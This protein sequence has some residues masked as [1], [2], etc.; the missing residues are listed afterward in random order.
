M[1]IIGL[2]SYT[3]ESSCALIKDG[4]VIAHLEEERFNREKHTCKFPVNAIRECLKIGGITIHDVDFYTFFWK[5]EIE[6]FKNAFHF[7]K[8]FPDSIN[9]LREPK[10]K[11]SNEYAFFDRLIKQ[12]F[13][14]R[15]IQ[16]TFNLKK[17]P[18]VHYVEHH[19]CHAAS[20]YYL[21]SFNK[22][23]ILTMDGRGEST[24]T[25]I[26]YGQENAIKKLRE[27]TVP[28]SLGHLYAAFTDFLGFKPFHDE[29]K[30]MGMSAYGKENFSD[31][32]DKILC[33]D[34]DGIYKLN[35]SY[36]KFHVK[37]QQQ[38][39]SPKV[40]SL[41]GP[42]RNQGE[43]LLQR[44]Y[45]I[46]Y[47]L[48][49]STEK[50]GIQLAQYTAKITKASNLCLTGGVALNCLMNKKIIENTDFENYFIQPIANDAGASL[51]SAL[52]FYHHILGHN[53]TSHFDS[54]YLGN[55]FSNEEIEKVL[56]NKK[57]V[58]KKSDNI[59]KD[60]AK[61]IVDQKIVGWFQGKME[62]G[63]RA[64]G[65]RSIVVD[66]RN[67]A[68]K[69]T[70]NARVKR[71]EGFRPFAP[72]VLEEKSS[73]YF[74][75]P[76][77]QKSPYM[78]LIGDVNE[79]KIDKIPAVVHADNTARVHTV[80]KNQNSKYWHLIS[81]FEK[82]SGIPVLLNTSFNENEPI[83]CTPEEAVN[84]FLRTDFDILAIGDYIIDKCEQV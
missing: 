50:A 69:D 30:V 14:A 40:E 77:N 7:I 29:W 16:K 57:V 52:Y 61:Y 1:Y 70:L 81:E 23:A 64:L 53:T 63:P 78:I 80:N 66:P 28:H 46:A 19:L 67:S 12:K 48:Q 32:F 42:K 37:G 68:M 36:F 3:H 8:Y 79:D 25:M 39:L 15:E 2:S 35:L 11:T 18:K 20:A 49:K 58:Y 59:E 33:F 72:S 73:D 65:N 84:C 75:L 43:P 62:S 34:D 54:I 10:D 5:P 44:H 38:W 6:L 71:R 51:G 74:S 82:L 41:L 26:S 21:S 4:K 45:D 24:C 47:A 83:V 22:S 76:K 17:K 60:T 31:A 55:E 13:I 9:L 27:I 56:I